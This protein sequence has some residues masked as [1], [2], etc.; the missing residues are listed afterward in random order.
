MDIAVIKMLI[1][2]SSGTVCELS[3]H[4]FEDP[5]GEKAI[6][7]M[8]AEDQ[9]LMRSWKELSMAL[10]GARRPHLGSLLRD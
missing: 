6:S 1:S 5:A 7:T 9:A 3:D 8:S 4:V 10:L 2:L